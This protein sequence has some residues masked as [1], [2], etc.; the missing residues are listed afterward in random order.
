[1]ADQVLDAKGL[2]CPLPILRAKKALKELPPGGTLEIHATDPGAVKD[3]EAFCR[4]TGHDLL[5]V[6][7]VARVVIVAACGW[8]S[9]LFCFPRRDR[10][11][12]HRHPG[13]RR[14]PRRS[15]TARCGG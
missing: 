13:R 9:Y 14:G 1:M 5:A 4:S 12:V 10:D 6:E 11:P 3:F 7:G 15:R 2:N 8:E